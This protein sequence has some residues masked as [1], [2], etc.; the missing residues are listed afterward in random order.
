MKLNNKDL[1][2]Y[3]YCC[4]GVSTDTRA[5]QENALFICLK[6]EK[7]DGNKFASEALSKG[8]KYAVIDNPAYTIEGKTILVENT[9]LFL[10]ELAHFHRL[11]FNIPIIGITGSNG[12][13]STKELIKEVLQKKYNTHYTLGNLNN[14]I[15][16]PLTLLQL[17][18]SHEIAIIEMGANKPHDIKEL[19]NIAKPTH[20]IITNIG[21]AHLE[22]FIDFNGVLATKKELYDSIEENGTHIIYN[23]DDLI[24]SNIVPKSK[25]ITTYGTGNNADIQGDLI[26]LNPYVQL[27]WSY[28]DFQSHLVQTSMIGKYNFYNFLSAISFGVIFDVSAEHINQAIQ[29]YV[30]TN[31]RSQVKKTDKN[32][33]LLDCYN[34][35]PTSMRSAIESFSLME[36]NNK[37]FILGDMLELGAETIKEHEAIIQQ[38]TQLN[39]QGYFVGSIFY[40]LKH[41]SDNFFESREELLKALIDNP[42]SEKLI[43]IKGSRGIGLETVEEIL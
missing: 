23:S 26:A 33:L 25:K 10:Q 6:G 38:T 36:G 37:C 42:I 35:N 17:N 24:L 43:L 40:S 22:G 18:Q 28:K 4:N 5:I 12:K 9:L 30:P 2:E 20:G 7:F 16:V 21:K 31:N 8:A 14:H 15:G 27:Q 11:Q 39:L 13:T 19:C 29:E 3:F 32:T 1:Y 34:A 41:Q